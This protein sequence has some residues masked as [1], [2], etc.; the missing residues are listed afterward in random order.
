LELLSLTFDADRP[1]TK[2]FIQEKGEPW[3]Q[4]IVGPLA[5]AISLGYGVDDENVPATVLIGPDGKI[6]ARDLRYDKI[7]TAVGQAL[8]L[9]PK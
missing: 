6:V 8:A 1:E 7:S 3:T 2:K 5:N 4:A 9:S